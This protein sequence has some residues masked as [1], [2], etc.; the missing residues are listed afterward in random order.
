MPRHPS[1]G[2]LACL[3]PLIP[4]LALAWPPPAGAWERTR[5]P[6]TGVCLWSE[7][8][9]LDFWLDEECEVEGSRA[10]CWEAVASALE[11]WNRSGCSDLRLRLVGTR[12][13]ARIESDLDHPEDNARVIRVDDAGRA[14]R[15][16]RRAAL[17]AALED[18][19]S[20]VT[21]DR[22]SGRIVDADIEIEL[23]G[24]S[25]D[26]LHNMILHEA[27][28]ALGLDHARSPRAVMFP[29]TP[30]EPRLAALGADELAALCALY[31]AGQPTPSCTPAGPVYVQRR[32]AASLEGGSGCASAG[33]SGGLA[34]LLG[35]GL[36]LGRGRRGR[37]G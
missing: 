24:L 35:L 29:S 33:G 12:R 9:Q 28:H 8:R 6:F 21:Y 1:S 27:G 22:A 17:A 16:T 26:T 30:A 23:P 11:S 37:R 10:A 19:H 25:A 36:A 18:G 15:A 20:V 32:F 3:A 5:D 34:L 7:A 31:P 13:A 4:L 2:P 14:G